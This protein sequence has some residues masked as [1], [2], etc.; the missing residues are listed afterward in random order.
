MVVNPHMY[1]KLAYSVDNDFAPIALLA[2]GQFVLVVHPDVP[3]KNVTEL[4]AHLKANPGKLNYAS[5]GIGS[6]LHMAGELFMAR[7]GTKMVHIPYKGGGEAARA[8]LA[9]DAQV[10]F[11]SPATLGPSISAGK[12][13]ALA[14]TGP[15]RLSTMPE[16][17][18]LSD[19]GLPGYQVTV[20]HSLLAPAGTPQPVLERFQ[21]EVVKALN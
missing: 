7:T 5:A 3:A 10:L 21:R 15:K 6:P 9:G 19:S 13:R 17:A 11:G 20:W 4:I 12:M 2:E 14:V 1:K 18:T 8:V 16:L